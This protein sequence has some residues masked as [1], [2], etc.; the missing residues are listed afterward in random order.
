MDGL[1]IDENDS[2]DAP[3]I[4]LAVEVAPTLMLDLADREALARRVLGFARRL[5][6]SKP[7]QRQAIA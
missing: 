1:L 2:T 7:T 6:T 4:D 3:A 5:A